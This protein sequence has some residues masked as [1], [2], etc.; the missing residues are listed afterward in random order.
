[1]I[2]AEAKAIINKIKNRGFEAMAVGGCVR[3]FLHYNIQSSDI[4]IATTSTPEQTKKIFLN[5]KFSIISDAEKFGCIMINSNETG[6]TYEITTLRSDYNQDGRHTDIKFESS[7]LED[8]KRRDFTMNALYSDIDG[9]IL[10]YHNG[11]CDL[12]NNLVRFVGNPE[13]RICED[14]LRIMR[15]FRF[16]AKFN[17]SFDE[18]GFNACK[19]YQHKINTI[20]TERF[21]G[22][23]VKICR[24]EYNNDAIFKMQEIGLFNS[25]FD[26]DIDFNILPNCKDLSKKQII[27]ILFKKIDAN[28][29]AKL[30]LSNNDKRFIYN[31]NSVKNDCRI[32]NFYKIE[33]KFL[34]EILDILGK[35]LF[36][37]PEC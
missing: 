19:K 5:D 26:T 34:Q 3:D 33:K 22:E 13:D 29:V 6:I 24:Q 23:L 9:N 1:M 16:C 8:S 12:K 28:I 17:N 32:C 11:V 25:W 27:A 4:D 15:F 21:T 37:S 14:Y 7:F 18:I 20:S 35:S 31:Y 2:T 30:D 10:D 36:T